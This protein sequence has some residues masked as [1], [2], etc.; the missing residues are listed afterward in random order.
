MS[1]LRKTVIAVIAV[2][3]IVCI[4]TV[5]AFQLSPWPRALLIR[6]SFD[7]GGAATAA[8]L[9]R[10][11]PEGVAEML[12]IRYLPDDP[13]ANLDVFFPAGIE[14][15]NA[16]LATIVWIH[17]GAFVAG[18]KH[19]IGNYGRIL[20]SYGFTV[21]GVDYSI[22]PE[23]TY[24]TPLR[25][26]NAALAYLAREAPHL[27]VDPSRFVL[28]GDSAGAQIAAQMA[29]MISDASFASDVGIA[30]AIARPDLRGVILHCGPYDVD[31][32]DMDGAFGGFLSTILWAYLGRKDFRSDPRIGQ[33]SVV[34]H[35]T[36]DFPPAFIS[37]GNGDPLGP[38]SKALA[39]RLEQLGV[40]VD[41]LFVADD[42]R[43]ALAH[44]YQ[45]NLD[46]VEGQRA[47]QRTIEFLGK[48]A[49]PPQ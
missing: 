13:N 34:R 26:V 43:P 37:A 7:K 47:L 3:V 11:V 29:A 33:L 17:G 28:A 48:V 31:A 38:Q 46:G 27:H 16:R 14:R 21:V 41:T 9:E 23:A 25:Q 4:V 39:S 6:R 44:E 35:V 18:S 20:A 15:S 36:A 19:D 42:Y 40:P 24:P 32:V 12:D 5:A 8:A 45:F 10:H 30:P 49:A 2:A 22:A 1:V